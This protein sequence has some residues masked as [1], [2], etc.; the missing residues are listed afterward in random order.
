MLQQWVSVTS[1]VTWKWHHHIKKYPAAFLIWPELMSSL[2]HNALEFGQKHYNR[3]Q[4]YFKSFCSKYQ[5]TT[6]HHCMMMPL[7]GQTGSDWDS[8]LQHRLGRLPP[9]PKSFFSPTDCQ[10]EPVNSI[11]L[12][13]KRS[14][15]LKHYYTIKVF[16][17][18]QQLISA[19][20][21]A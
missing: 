20:T 13:F 10:E 9:P 21:V 6:Q 12:T 17:Y 19:W 4:I 18:V 7:S 11:H 2:Q 3:S 16:Y 8:L 1:N 14:K 5:S 15:K